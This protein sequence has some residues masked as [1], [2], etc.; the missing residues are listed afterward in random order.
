MHLTPAPFSGYPAVMHIRRFLFALAAS[1]ALAAPAAAQ[2]ANE[3]D[4]G[5]A[6]RNGIA[7]SWSN[8]PKSWAERTIC[9]SYAKAAAT[10]AGAITCAA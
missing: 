1:V 10:S 7:A 9:A 5:C 4:N 6:A 3:E 8:C 2:N